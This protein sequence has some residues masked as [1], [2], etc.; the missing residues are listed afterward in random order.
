MPDIDAIKQEDDTYLNA[1]GAAVNEGGHLIDDE[2][3]LINDDGFLVNELGQLLSATGEAVDM[4]GNLIDKDS[5]IIDENNNDDK[6]HM[7]P[8]A[9]YDTAA[10]RAADAEEELAE[11]KKKLADT[12]AAS[13]GG[14]K[15]EADFIAEIDALDVKI[16]AARKDGDVEGVVRLNKE[17]RDMERGMYTAIA[18]Q[19]ANNAGTK[20][21]QKIAL[22]N[23]I[24][25]LEGTHEFFDPNSKKFDQEL[26]DEVLEMQSAFMLKGDTPAAAMAKAV[27]YVVPMAKN[28]AAARGTDHKKNLG[29]AK[30]Q[31][32]KM[33]ETGRASDAGG[34][35]GDVGNV[36]DMTTE[37]FDALPKATKQRLRGDS[38]VS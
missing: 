30:A 34:D 4:E 18:E 6:G 23:L 8:K 27:G 16:E 31:A 35:K 3:A 14:P 38:Y 19:H 11:A 36:G 13:G 25:D 26:V 2:G 37:E 9:R 17:Q 20:A 22:D 32:P 1:A 33:G 5:K 29:A 21:Q 10:R 7:V 28:D 12:T 15:T 24:T